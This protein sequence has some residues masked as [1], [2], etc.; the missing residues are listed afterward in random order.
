MQ[1]P[2]HH[3]CAFLRLRFCGKNRDKFSKT[4]SESVHI[5]I[6]IM[7]TCFYLDI[8]ANGKQK[9]ISLWKL[10]IPLECNLIFFFVSLNIYYCCKINKKEYSALKKH[11][12]TGMITL[13]TRFCESNAFFFHWASVLLNFFMNWSLN[14]V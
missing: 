2:P 5:G 11:I 1:I 10:S 9:W 12:S 7:M 3:M 14:V 8:W 13:S 4:P 6:N